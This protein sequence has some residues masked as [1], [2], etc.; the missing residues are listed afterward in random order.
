MLLTEISVTSDYI[1]SSKENKIEA[2]LPVDT[3]QLK[4]HALFGGILGSIFVMLAISTTVY[5]LKLE[6]NRKW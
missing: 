5:S 4:R 1:M 3:P 6:T 2:F